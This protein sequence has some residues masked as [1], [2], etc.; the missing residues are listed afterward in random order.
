MG[1][2]SS[3]EMKGGAA[4]GTLKRKRDPLRTVVSA[5]THLIRH[6]TLHFGVRSIS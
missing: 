2:L 5:S 3:W 1:C 6:V 4:T